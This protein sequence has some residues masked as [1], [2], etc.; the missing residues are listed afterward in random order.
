MADIKVHINDHT[1]E[2]DTSS[3]NEIMLRDI[4]ISRLRSSGIEVITNRAVGQRIL[5]DYQ[6]GILNNEIRLQSVFHGSGANF[7]HFDTRHHLSEGEG[8][9]VFGVGTYVTA[10][11]KVAE[12][13]A[14]I[15]SLTGN[16]DKF[17]AVVDG[18]S[19]NYND[20]KHATDGVFLACDKLAKFGREEAV[21]AL[22]QNISDYVQLG[23]SEKEAEAREALNYLNSHDIHVPERGRY[24]YTVDIPDDNGKNFLYWDGSLTSRQAETIRES[25]YKAVLER[26]DDYKGSEKF[27]AQ[28]LSVI[29][30]GSHIGDTYG[31]ISDYLGSDKVASEFLSGLGYTGIKVH[32]DHFGN[33]SRYKDDWNYVIFNEKDLGIKDKIKFFKA[34]NGDAYGFTV[35]NKIYVDPKI[36]NSETPIHEY[37]HMWAAALR[38]G[39]K[40][41]WANVVNLMKSQTELWDS[42]R[43]RYPQLTTDD[44]IADEV[45][46]TYSGKRGSERL[47]EQVSRVMGGDAE[48]SN[49]FKAFEEAIKR[50]WHD[51][52]DMLHIHYDSAEQVADQVMSDMLHGVNPIEVKKKAFVRQEFESL[53]DS[54]KNFNERLSSLMKDSHQK[55]QRLRLG[56]ASTF[57][58]EGGLADG[59]IFLQYNKILKKSS[60]NYENNH[61]YDIAS[62]RNL[63]MAIAYPISVFE[64]TNDKKAGSTILTELRGGDHNFIVAVKTVSEHRANGVNM[65]INDITTLFPKDEKGIVN[66]YNTGKATNIDKKKALRF[67]SSLQTHSGNEINSEELSSAANIINKFEK[68]KY[69]ED[70]FD[71]TFKEV[72]SDRRYVEAVAS[73]HIGEARQ[74]LAERAKS[75]GYLP[76][77]YQGK[78]SWTA[79]IAEVEP[80]DFENKEALQQMVDD[81]GRE[82]NVYG[83]INGIQ[84]HDSD[85]YYNPNAVGFHGKAA[86]E[87]SEILRRLRD[88]HASGDTLV[89]IYRVLPNTVLGSQIMQGDWVA[90]SKAYC[91]DLG[92]H[93]YGEGNYH[94]L[95]S[96]API[97]NLWMGDED[98]REFGFDD[99]YGDV[100][101][102][103]RNNR[104]LLDITYDDEGNL[105][106]LSQRFNEGKEDVKFQLSD[107]NNFKKDSSQTHMDEEKEKSNEDHLSSYTKDV[108]KIFADRMVK[109]MQ[110]MKASDYKQGWAVGSGRNM[111]PMNITG[112]TFDGL[113]ILM[114]NHDTYKN[115]YVSPIYMTGRQ[116]INHGW[117]IKEEEKAKALPILAYVPS[118]LYDGKFINQKKYDELSSEE[119]DKAKISFILRVYKEYNLDQTN[120]ADVNPQLY[121][122]LTSFG[123]D[124]R[125]A[126][127]SGG[128]YVSP[129]LDRM[130]KNQ[131]WVCP[132]RYDKPSPEA[133]YNPSD[134]RIVV[135]MK[136]QYKISKT[137]EEVFKDGQAYYADVLHE[138]AHSTGHPS[139][140]DRP[141][142][143]KAGDEN[144]AREELV[145]ELSSA[146]VSSALGFDK[147]ID[148]N[149]AAYLDGWVR[150]LS[151]NPI[152]IKNL[153]SPVKKASMMILESIDKQRI[154]LG[155]EPLVRH[156][157]VDLVKLVESQSVKQDD[158]L[159]KDAIA[160]GYA[161]NMEKQ[162]DEVVK[163]FGQDENLFD[164]LTAAASGQPLDSV[165]HTDKFDIIHDFINQYG[166]KKELGAETETTTGAL[167]NSHSVAQLNLNDGSVLEV[168]DYSK[169]FDDSVKDV[170]ELSHVRDGAIIDSARKEIGGVNQKVNQEALNNLWSAFVGS[171]PMNRIHE[172]QIV[173]DKEKAVGQETLRTENRGKTKVISTGNYYN[174]ET[175]RS[176]VFALHWMW[177]DLLNGRDVNNHLS[178]YVMSRQNFSHQIKAGNVSQI[179]PSMLMSH[180]LLGNIGQGNQDK[181]VLVPIPE[182]TG[183]ADYTLQLAEHIGVQT[184]IEVSDL[185]ESKEH[186]EFYD[187]K[188][189][190]DANSIDPE[191]VD[192]G[193][194]VKDGMQLPNGKIPI[195]VD[196]VLDTGKTIS[197]SAKALNA[198][199]HMALVFANTDKW[200][201]HPSYNIEVASPV[202]YRESKDGKSINDIVAQVSRLVIVDDGNVKDSS[203]QRPR[204][205]QAAVGVNYLNNIRENMGKA[206]F[207]DEKNW[208]KPVSRDN[209][210]TVHAERVKSVAD[211][212][213]LDLESEVRTLIDKYEDENAPRELFDYS[214]W[215]DEKLLAYM[216]LDG[217]G[218]FN[219]AMNVDVYEEYDTRHGKEYDEAYDKA[220]NMH[221]LGNTSFSEAVRLLGE[222]TVH[223][224]VL[225][226]PDRT[227]HLAHQDALVDYIKDL[228]KGINVSRSVEVEHTNTVSPENVIGSAPSVEVDTIKANEDIQSK[229]NEQRQAADVDSM[230]VKE[231]ASMSKDWY[232]PTP[233]LDGEVTDS[234]AKLEV[235]HDIKG[236]L[237]L[238]KEHDT[239]AGI[240]IPYM[241]TSKKPIHFEGDKFLGEDN[242]YALVSNHT[243]A[244]D[245]YLLYKRMSEVELLSHLQKDG[246]GKELLPENDHT[247][248][249]DVRQL[250]NQYVKSSQAQNKVNELA[251]ESMKSQKQVED[252]QSLRYQD[253]KWLGVPADVAVSDLVSGSRHPLS[254]IKDNNRIN[255]V[256]LHDDIAVARVYIFDKTWENADDIFKELKKEGFSREIKENEFSGGFADGYVDFDNFKE[257]AAFASHVEDI[258]KR[259][260]AARRPDSLMSAFNHNEVTEVTDDVA[261]E[262]RNALLET[263]RR[264]K[265]VGYDD[266]EI[267]IY[268]ANTK[269]YWEDSSTMVSAI[270]DVGK[271]YIRDWYVS[272]NYLQNSEDTAVFEELESKDDYKGML[273]EARNYDFSAE[274]DWDLQSTFKVS[275]K[276]YTGDDFLDE[277]DDYAIVKNDSVGGTYTIFRRATESE[278]RDEAIRQ[279]YG[280]EKIG[281]YGSDLSDDVRTL[282]NQMVDEK[283]SAEQHNAEQQSDSLKTIEE[284]LKEGGHDE[285]GSLSPSDEDK[286]QLDSSKEEIAVV[287]PSAANNQQTY[288]AEV[289]AFMNS[290]DV[291]MFDEV[292]S[293]EESLLSYASQCDPGDAIDQEYTYKSPYQSKGDELLAEDGNYAVVFNDELGNNSYTVLRKVSESD[294]RLNID[295]YGLSQEASDDVIEV[296]KKYEAEKVAH[297]VEAG[298]KPELGEGSM[299]KAFYQIKAEHP[300]NLLLFQS[301]NGDF[302]N[303][304]KEDARRVSEIL[305]LPL[306]ESDT[307]KDRNGQFVDTC[308]FPKHT[309]S[310]YLPKLVRAGEKAI[311][312]D[313][314]II[315]RDESKDKQKTPHEDSDM[316][317]D[318]TDTAKQ[319][320][321]SDNVP[322]EQ[323]EKEAK[324]NAVAQQKK[325]SKEEDSKILFDGTREEA[326]SI[327]DAIQPYIDDPDI[328]V[329]LDEWLKATDGYG[330]PFNTDKEWY[331]KYAKGKTDHQLV[332]L[333]HNAKDF[334]ELVPKEDDKKAVDPIMSVYG[335]M[336]EEHPNTILLFK[337]KSGKFYN[338]YM[339]DA[340]TVSEILRLP[341][342]KSDEVKDKDGKFVDNC[343]FPSHA[344][345]T[346]LP[347]LVRAGERS[348]LLD[349]PP[350]V[351]DRIKASKL[352]EV[353]QET[354]H[355]DSDMRTDVT[356]TAKHI[357]AS[358]NVPM[359]Q[360]EKE[361]KEIADEQVHKDYHQQQDKLHAEEEKRKQQE[362]QEQEK[363]HKV[364]NS[365]LYD[366]FGMKDGKRDIIKSGLT[367]IAAAN[368]VERND[369]RYQRKGYDYLIS[370]P[371]VEEKLE[372]VKSETAD[373]AKVQDLQ[374][375]QATVRTNSDETEENNQEQEDM[376]NKEEQLK[377]QAKKEEELHKEESSMSEPVTPKASSDDRA[378]EKAEQIKEPSPKE[379]E[380]VVNTAAVHAGLLLGALES[381]KEGIWLNP[382]G[383]H[384]AALLEPGKMITGYN[385]L[386]MDL[387]A[388]KNHY[389]T[390]VFTYYDYAKKEEMPVK[391]GQTSLPIDWTRWDYENVAT[392]EVITKE[393]YAEL[394]PDKQQDYARHSTK[395]TRHLYNIDQTAMAGTKVADYSKLVK[396]N[397]FKFEDIPELPTDK[398]FLNL[399]NRLHG[400]HKDCTII[401]GEGDKNFAYGAH[402]E[403]VGSV[404][405]APVQSKDIDGKKVSYIEF[406]HN[407]LDTVLPKMIGSHNKVAL[408][409]NVLESK[410][411]A[412]NNI[413]KNSVRDAA[414]VADKVSRKAGFTLERVLD[415]VPVS[416]DKEKDVITYSGNN[417]RQ[418]GRENLAAV[419][420]ANDIY[421]AVVE[422]TGRENRLDREARFN[423]LPEDNAKYEK[424]VQEL[425]SGVLMA[426]HGLPAIISKENRELIPYWEREIKENPKMMAVLEKDVNNSIEQIEKHLL[427]ME[428]D[429]AKIRGARPALFDAKDYTVASKMAQLPNADTKEFVIIRNAEKT[430]A[431]VILPEGATQPEGASLPGMSKERIAHALAKENIK[432]VHFYNAGGAQG[433]YK[434]N[435]YFAGKTATLT[436][437]KQWEL[438]PRHVVDISSQYLNVEK[439][440]LIERFKVI[441]DENK[442]K[443]FYI[444]AKGEGQFSVYPAKDYLNAYFTALKNPNRVERSKML[445]TLAQRYYAV[446]Q[447]H[448]EVKKEL[449]MPKLP[450]NVDM[451]KLVKA[452]INRNG[453]KDNYKY[454]VWAT[455]SGTHHKKEITENGAQVFH[456]MFLADDMQAYKNAVAANV[457]ESLIRTVKVQEADEGLKIVDNSNV[458]DVVGHSEKQDQGH[459]ESH[460]DGGSSD[461]DDKSESEGQGVGDASSK[462]VDKDKFEKENKSRGFHM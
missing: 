230:N 155:M 415:D 461:S 168:N 128:M 127:D 199:E 386:M 360:A 66:W 13:Y 175:D 315:N 165:K 134:D 283:L 184:G 368:F 424:L 84:G 255:L 364:L 171:A 363:K 323:A 224:D 115:D 306:Q 406:P 448:P 52:A 316:R 455:I 433:L 410:F 276:H 146:L 41:E 292:K 39:N 284:G 301:E 294:V 351:E 263:V 380:K 312:V 345:D 188:K 334:L 106:P 132:I 21:N 76:A 47:R 325:E 12:Q 217:G 462:Q 80:T 349:Y 331:K 3:S 408:C 18:V 342:Q 182:H 247:V 355:E 371:H 15:A 160:D 447:A 459:S 431:D 377:Q 278:V 438:L 256:N 211:Q 384:G 185:L 207:D 7:D 82:A 254:F 241:Y 456:H 137:P 264:M 313:N 250:V 90:L 375:Q 181:Y 382:H 32:T 243:A 229:V 85:Y 444:K 398:N 37:A 30:E 454:F 374:Q 405:G 393:Q 270:R 338:S 1:L 20:P 321:A 205:V 163:M 273:Q 413:S 339:E 156:G 198:K 149:S 411:E 57:L 117:R 429:Y 64:N 22:K 246:Y 27:L 77:D 91:D 71:K 261:K 341:L 81:F 437:L 225:V 126:K 140:L 327:V 326:W 271:D 219:H 9:Q 187:I 391:Q 428:V 170:Q 320:V 79:P 75:K 148:K 135:P 130:F 300:N 190:R 402:A 450:K 189:N 147:R 46:A 192:F 166:G 154:A 176:A 394:T 118:Y 153:M 335:Q 4:L 395:Q 195:L 24:L 435:D 418:P 422:A 427:G 303:S 186:A 417:A 96:K 291:Q 61:P 222:M 309:L 453:E 353:K 215:S 143:Q 290:E 157:E 214:N 352:S 434:D 332:N 107:D 445:T 122:K 58:R 310:T 136:Q 357:V 295:R 238:A 337:S 314:P 249:K 258:Q 346:Y 23:W 298:K 197:D 17:I 56:Y 366:V 55:D 101:K 142:I 116:I 344:L 36:A 5:D 340:S 141:F 272:V 74:M 436:K 65:E 412:S 209:Y 359:E 125:V 63:P 235:N 210:L 319:I 302:I 265:N 42:V 213:K 99:G 226:T 92:K 457:F 16:K 204:F 379:D 232:V 179:E 409:S 347:M 275:P 100:E 451:S 286:K 54:N 108:M 234:L 308:L 236:M 124:G 97:K 311:L 242:D 268:L 280:E 296:A 245:M 458:K 103:V 25:L 28:E 150:H 430:A 370:M 404:M 221:T 358:D 240:P 87:T 14:N 324:E 83:I 43:A 119:K 277:D 426:A 129:E 59:M 169:A 356:D 365:K 35:N 208:N 223:T 218:E 72:C 443:A 178:D 381:A 34:A 442:K 423:M 317:S 305:R 112:R 38:A 19:F 161:N 388:D 252:T 40:Q 162:W 114:A 228:N 285:S 304:Y 279:G 383:K 193:I 2:E 432:E 293:N 111:L 253:G 421:R 328:T 248:S 123:E 367:I 138:M 10:V 8:N 11:R 452:T 177:S 33:D 196:N 392:K 159:D 348:V 31:T 200:K 152:Y 113:N 407:A 449:I 94:V 212:G 281:D 172:K 174:T 419:E 354:P 267:G 385:R 350:F 299:M 95:K 257:A 288:Y 139:R 44:D 322:M 50:F 49:M 73:G 88:E 145:A 203:R 237:D 231:K 220:Y 262:F 131:Q 260:D 206:W 216:K 120:V 6:N 269:D 151:D 144:Y 330:T 51:V 333:Y 440:P 133:F 287:K 399:T 173:N 239:F 70:N 86:D 53:V 446:A 336:K 69:Q 201:E 244:G 29:K 180:E 164:Q 362:Q 307:V 110:E 60:E 259:I 397:G 45:L 26:N 121:A 282:V 78:D 183:K 425:S 416:Y 373:I 67:I 98:M 202:H 460:S 343:T 68:A 266:R 329:L 389:K 102:N 158:T 62:L 48:S 227:E 233:G 372:K 441:S 420:K 378:K 274:N 104:K 93:K 396:D 297:K 361:A 191:K 251:T 109:M 289:A 105:I 403:K 439:K 390:N 414:T 89:N 376:N 318:V 369:E 400:K 194:K 401:L 387:F 167:Y